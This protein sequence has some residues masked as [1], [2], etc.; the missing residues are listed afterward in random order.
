MPAD[1]DADCCAA[2]SMAQVEISAATLVAMDAI[3][4]NTANALRRD[5]Q[6]H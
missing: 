5:T 2:A 1:V 3:V 4:V 6:A